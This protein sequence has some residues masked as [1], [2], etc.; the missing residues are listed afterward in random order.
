MENV[1]D[2]VVL[3]VTDMEAAFA[4]VVKCRQEVF[5]HPSCRKHHRSNTASRIP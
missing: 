4:A 1:V 2:E 5:R 3:F